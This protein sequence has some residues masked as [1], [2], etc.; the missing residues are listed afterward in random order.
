ML[1]HHGL[2]TGRRHARKHL[3]WALDAAADTAGAPDALLK[4]HRIRVLTANDEAA[5]RRHL[6]DAYA[7][8]ASIAA[9]KPASAWSQK[10]RHT[11]YGSDGKAACV[12]TRRR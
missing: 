2:A 6:A 9:A 7:D 12:G 4:A 11:P 8:F 3:G 10:A 5:V 1:S